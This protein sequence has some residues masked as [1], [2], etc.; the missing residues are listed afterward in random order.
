M[1]TGTEP[2]NFWLTTIVASWRIR[3]LLI[4]DVLARIRCTRRMVS[5]NRIRGAGGVSLN[6]DRMLKTSFVC[7]G[8]LSSIERAGSQL[9][10]IKSS[11]SLAN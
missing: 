9:R 8:I 1:K 3:G 6:S 10:A 7:Q 5:R 11:S 2:C 4:E